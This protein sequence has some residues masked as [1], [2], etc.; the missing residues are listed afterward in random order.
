MNKIKLKRPGPA[1]R[2][3]TFDHRYPK[4]T[5][6]NGCCVTEMLRFV[7]RFMRLSYLV[8]L[9]KFMVISSHFWSFQGD[10][11]VF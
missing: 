4:L 2:L 8:S 7:W 3:F 5:S 11:I 9:S 10:S 1:F 6:E